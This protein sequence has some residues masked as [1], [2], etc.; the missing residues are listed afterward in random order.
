MT[1]KH[2]HH[3]EKKHD[4]CDEN[5]ERKEKILNLSFFIFGLVF[6][7]SGFV[8]EKISGAK[9]P[10]PYQEITWSLFKDKGFYTSYAFFSVLLYTIGYIP[11]LIKILISCIEE[12]AYRRG[13]IT[14][15]QLLKLAEPLMKTA[16]GQYLVD[17]ANGL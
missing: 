3:D 11:L 5:K 15:D 9:D 16:Y 1:C 7:I 17:V 8:L 12:I 4:C 10:V 13:F 14:R 6:L 2:C